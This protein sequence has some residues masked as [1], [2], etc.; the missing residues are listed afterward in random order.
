M[1]SENGEM[2]DSALV[3]MIEAS[4][5]YALCDFQDPVNDI[6]A[7]MLLSVA[8]YL[9]QLLAIAVEARINPTAE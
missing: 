7:A 5:A 2:P 9:P 6:Y 8:P 3:E 1:W 4:N